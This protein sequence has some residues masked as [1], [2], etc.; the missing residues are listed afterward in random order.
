MA[1]YRDVVR[2]EIQIKA[3]SASIMGAPNIIKVTFLLKVVFFL[4]AFVS[5]SEGPSKSKSTPLN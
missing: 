3:R 1:T 4:Y 2:G 5:N